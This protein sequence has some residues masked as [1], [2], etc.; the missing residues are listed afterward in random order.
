MTSCADEN[1]KDEEEAVILTDI[2]VNPTLVVPVG[3]KVQITATPVPENATGV[4]FEWSSEDPSAATVYS[5]GTV[6]VKKYKPTTTTITVKSGSVVKTVEVEIVI[7]ASGI[8]VIDSIKL[9]VVGDVVTITATPVP[10]NTTYPIVW[11]SGDP[12]IATVEES[13]GKVT[14]I[15]EGE[16]TLTVNVGEKNATVVVLVGLEDLIVQPTYL[17]M[18]A[19]NT[20]QIT[21][22]AVPDADHIQ[23]EWKSLNEDVA[24]VDGYGKVTALSEGAATITVR[25][26][27]KERE[28]EVEVV[29]VT[30]ID[31]SPSSLILCIDD[32]YSITA[33]ATPNIEG[34]LYSWNSSNTG[35]ATVDDYGN[36]TART[37]GETTISV[38][39][40]TIEKTIDVKV[41]SLTV[42]PT[43][44]TI[45]VDEEKQITATPDR[46]TVT[47]VWTSSNTGVAT[48]DANGKVKGTA[49]GDAY[50]SVSYGQATK[51]VHV[52][53]KKEV[54]F[55]KT[56]L[57]W[58]ITVSDEDVT[59]GGGK[60]KMIDD[61]P[62]VTNTAQPANYWHS[63]SG[64]LPH[65]A[66]ID[67]KKKYVITKI[68]VL[69]RAY[70]HEE[71]SW[72]KTTY[73]RGDTKTVQCLVGDSENG[74][75]TSLVEGA[76]SSNGNEQ[77]NY[78]AANH[79]L[80]MV[81]STRNTGQQYL[82]LNMPDGFRTD[83]IASICEVYV[84]GYEPAE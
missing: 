2:T 46:A 4:W 75:W 23:Y 55:S 20:Q 64:S 26:G 17:K 45:L 35:V 67:M 57:G 38:K 31:V 22:K 39:A 80:T 66:V 8:D 84:Y 7:P 28:V 42:T 25:S 60:G 79:Q 44:F 12:N 6:F 51:K 11:S 83:G 54:E 69:R 5:D 24:T 49:E 47:P 73:Y 63:I 34:L 14:A 1:N 53:V 65:W 52:Y 62:V 59:D 33:T 29:E 36:V 82:K 43:V 58:T 76:Y 56:A 70:K 21:A 10:A 50:I 9:P 16:T 48:V 30:A 78:N 3:G 72:L 19:G 77:T 40:G 74:S 41:I 71:G 68:I 13:T 15:S 32:E 27:S 37:T 18:V 81:V 61:D